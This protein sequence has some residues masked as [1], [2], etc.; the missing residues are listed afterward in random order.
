MWL[1]R[2]KEMISKEREVTGGAGPSLRAGKGEGVLLL[3]CSPHVL[4]DRERR[5]GPVLRGSLFL[6]VG[7]EVTFEYL[8]LPISTFN[9][10]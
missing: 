4:R 7:A 6:R 9:L 10:F 1:K 5:P 8:P 3:P 2:K